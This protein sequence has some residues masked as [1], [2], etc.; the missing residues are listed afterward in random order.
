MRPG[1]LIAHARAHVCDLAGVQVESVS[2]L[3]R[4]GNEE[5]V[6]TVEALE[7][8]RVPNTMDV[9]ATYEVRLSDEGELV[10]FRR[11]GRYQR[12]VAS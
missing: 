11:V 2:G 1:E 7:L 9:M 4:D 8:A 12:S 3:G 6:V 5:W 10:G